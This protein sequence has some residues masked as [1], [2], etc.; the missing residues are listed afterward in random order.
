MPEE[1]DCEACGHVILDR[2]HLEA[3]RGYLE[4]TFSLWWWIRSLCDCVLLG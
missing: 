3:Y 2:M 4:R 1:C